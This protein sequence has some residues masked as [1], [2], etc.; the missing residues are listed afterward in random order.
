MVRKFSFLNS[1]R[2]VVAGMDNSC[3]QFMFGSIKPDMPVMVAVLDLGTP[4]KRNYY[5][6][7]MEQKHAE[8]LLP[9]L[10]TLLDKVEEE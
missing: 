6:D 10:E 4:Q 3:L 7:N 1:H 5:L 9:F 8:G 2:L